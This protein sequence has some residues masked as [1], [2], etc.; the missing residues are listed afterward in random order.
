MCS[1]NFGLGVKS[2]SRSVIAGSYRIW[3][4]SSLER[5][6]ESSRATDC[7]FRRGNLSVR[8]PTPNATYVVDL[9]RRGAGVSPVSERGTTLTTVKVPK[10]QLSVK[11]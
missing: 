9:G 3:P 1:S 4:Q 2:Q 11:G 6:G 5:D 10:T 7:G 8:C